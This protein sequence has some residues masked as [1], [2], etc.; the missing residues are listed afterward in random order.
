VAK[1]KNIYVGCVVRPSRLIIAISIMTTTTAVTAASPTASP[2][3]TK[4]NV[5]DFMG[6][7]W[8]LVQ[9]PVVAV[10]V[11]LKS[12]TVGFNRHRSIMLS[13]KN[14]L[15]SSVT[16]SLNIAQIRTLLPVK[17]IGDMMKS[18]PDKR[19]LRNYGVAY[20]VQGC[21]AN[22]LVEVED[23]TPADPI[24]LYFHGGGYVFPI[25]PPHFLLLANIAKEL[26]KTSRLSI[27]LIDYSLAPECQFPGQIQEA[28]VLYHQLVDID[29]ATNVIF[30]GDSCGCN[31]ALALMGHIKHTFPSAIPIQSGTSPN[32]ACFMSPWVNVHATP[33]GSYQRYKHVDIVSVD[34]LNY[35]AEQY[36]PDEEMRQHNVW[37]NPLSSEE[38]Y[39]RD[40]IP[41]KMLV[42]WGEEEML[43]DDCARW[44]ELAGVSDTFEDPSGTHVSFL[45]NDKSPALDSILEFLKLVTV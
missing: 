39:W 17:S 8:T 30:M 22:W 19:Y 25:G 15:A 16:N 23:R 42:E 34:S 31:L 44:S 20:P 27:L 29:K 40:I 36:C 1:Q 26:Q 13:V 9:L 41:N 3:H 10:W 18:S 28:A 35:W 11:A 5:L 7:G 4:P 45:F 24:L 33:T 6:L 14:A 43:R 2:T 37:V 21:D 12:S 32:A 38:G